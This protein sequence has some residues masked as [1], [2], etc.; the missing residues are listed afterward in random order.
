MKGVEECSSDSSDIN[1]GESSCSQNGYSNYISEEDR[2]AILRRSR[3]GPPICTAYDYD[4]IGTLDYGDGMHFGKSGKMVD[5]PVK[6]V[7]MG[8]YLIRAHVE[9]QRN[10][11]LKEW[12]LV[13]ILSEDLLLLQR[14][15]GLPNEVCE[16]PVNAPAPHGK[17]WHGGTFIMERNIRRDQDELVA[18]L[19]D[20]P[21]V[22]HI[23]IF[24]VASTVPL[25]LIDLKKPK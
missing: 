12:T 9:L 6:W 25:R 19:R 22:D 7:N 20:V 21:G 24:L 10:I 4:I 14:K 18:I 17:W 13:D 2:D 11:E 16:G 23:D 15:N 1:T 3:T 5:N 8:L